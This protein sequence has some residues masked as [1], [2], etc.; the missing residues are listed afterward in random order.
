VWRLEFFTVHGALIAAANTRVHGQVPD[1]VQGTGTVDYV[2]DKLMLVQGGYDLS[3][4]F[5]DYECQHPYDVR[6]RFM[7][8]YVQRGNPPDEDGVVSLGGRW[9]GDDLPPY[10]R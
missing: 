7:R 5:F 8:F 6:H 3:A 9:R 1:I 4:T 10:V 2:V